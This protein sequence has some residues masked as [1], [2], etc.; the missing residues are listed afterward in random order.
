MNIAI[1]L[2]AG[3]HFASHGSVG[4]ASCDRSS[5]PGTTGA[6]FEGQ[7]VPLAVHQA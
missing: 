4:I 3:S 5:I 2:R 7:V 6:Q 1:F